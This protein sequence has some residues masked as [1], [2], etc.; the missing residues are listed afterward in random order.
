VAYWQSRPRERCVSYHPAEKAALF[1]AYSSARCCTTLTG[2]KIAGQLAGFERS[3]RAGRAWSMPA[4]VAATVAANCSRKE[5]T[6]LL[7]HYGLVG[8]LSFYIRKARER[9]G[10]THWSFIKPPPSPK[11]IFF[12]PGY[13]GRLTGH[14][15]IYVR[16]VDGPDLPGIGLPSG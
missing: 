10:P 12:L 16:E 6:L 9:V 11:T 14:N 8:H 4:A 3:V 7:E 5:A 13:K 1:L 2:H 15:A